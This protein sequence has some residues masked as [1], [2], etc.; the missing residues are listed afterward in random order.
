[1]HTTST[2]TSLNKER[3]E[4]P[5]SQANVKKLYTIMQSIFTFTATH[6]YMKEPLSRN[7]ILTSKKATT[8]VKHKYLLK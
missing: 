4:I 2:H 6:D 5:L 8:E 7:V 3:K 1:M